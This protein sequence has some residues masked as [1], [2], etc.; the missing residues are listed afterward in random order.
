MRDRR[1]HIKLD[2]YKTPT[3]FSSKPGR[4]EHVSSKM[5]CCRVG[6]TLL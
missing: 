3:L 1:N 2:N 6:R 5:P 4:E